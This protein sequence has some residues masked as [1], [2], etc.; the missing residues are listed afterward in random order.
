[1]KYHKLNNLEN[2]MS[3]LIAEGQQAVWLYIEEETNAFKRCEKR[4][5]YWQAL[6]KIRKGK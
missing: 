6:N 4:K 3:N 1:M 2:M 5:L